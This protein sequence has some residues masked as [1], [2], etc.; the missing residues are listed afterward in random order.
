MSP[1]ERTTH[2]LPLFSRL[3]GALC[4]LLAALCTPAI[5]QQIDGKDFASI[6]L[7]AP[8]QPFDIDIAANRVWAWTARH[9]NRLVLDRDVRVRIGPH[10]FEAKR[11]VAWIEPVVINEHEG[12]QLAFYFEGVRLSSRRSGVTVAP[13]ADA[14]DRSLLV[15]AIVYDSN[16]RLKTDKLTTEQPTDNPFLERAEQ[17]LARYL[18]EIRKQDADRNKQ[19]DKEPTP[20]PGGAEDPPHPPTPR[21][22][23]SPQDSLPARGIV[24][25]STTGTQTITDAEDGSRILMMT[26]GAVVQYAPPDAEPIQL[27]AQRAVVFLTSDIDRPAARVGAADVRGIYLEGDVVAR[28]Q[29]ASV[30]GSRVYYD[31]ATNR[32][33]ALDAVFW[34]YDEKRG[35]PLY[36]RA[37][38]IRQEALNQWSGEDVTLSNVA[39]A[40]PHFSIGAS[41]VTITHTQPANAPD[42]ILIDANRVSFRAGSIPLFGAS[43][44]HGQFK[45]SPLRAIDFRS[46]SGDP[47]IRTEWDAYTLL[48]LD[49]SEGNRATLLLD[50]YTERGPGVGLD[51]EW[52]QNDVVGNLLAYLI[53][54]N[55]TDRLTSGAEKEHDQEFRGMVLAEQSWQLDENWSIL[56]EAAYVSDET[57][58]DAFFEELAETRRPFMSGLTARRHDDQSLLLI[59]ASAS[60]NDFVVSESRLQSYGY[61]VEKLPEIFYARTADQLFGSLFS[62]SSEYRASRL[63]LSLSK[64]KL[65]EQGFDTRKRSRAAVGLDPNDTIAQRLRNRGYTEDDLYRLDTRH[66]L[67]MP[68]KL[69]AVNVVPFAVGRATFWDNDFASFAPRDDSDSL[70][71]WGA[72][73]ARASTSFVHIDR[74]AKNEILDI[75]GLRH[76]VEPNATVWHADTNIEQQDLPIYDDDVE[77]LAAGTT[78]RAGLRNTWQTKRGRSDAKRSVDLLTINSDYL[79]ASGDVEEESPY[80]RF[81]DA[82]PEHSSFGRFFANTAV[83]NLTSAFTLTSDVL[84]N[85]DAGEMA[86]QV[87][88]GILDHGNGFSSFAE[89]RHITAP[90]DELVSVGAAYELNRKY[91]MAAAV[92]HDIER[93]E[94]RRLGVNFERRFPQW[95]VDFVFEAD[96]ITSDVSFGFSL[97]PVGFAGETRTR[98]FTLDQGSYMPVRTPPSRGRIDYGPFADS[99]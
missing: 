70:R 1:S 34:T 99:K 69:G 62:Y 15:T 16:T 33:I 49:P 43:S 41:R 23:P 91:A 39:F 7:P 46:E 72:V 17:R 94:F 52:A 53:Y 75:D 93:G 50:A 45:P 89:Y 97:R 96:D 54:D 80:A 2:H 37:E 74:S 12:D 35:M 32:A 57:F 48:G 63:Q 29:A 66:E 73:G 86:R 14:E 21:D 98:A 88:G 40:E 4:A 6:D 84:F 36:M 95:T 51:L 19:P 22:D 11:A 85:T 83:L 56:A 65:R 31:L 47:I 13:N 78:F 82:R 55:G 27:T 8:A 68:L 20:A 76:I 77:S 38:A 87:Y 92:T 44:I 42:E 10:Q 64:N 60:L 3:A 90:D 28:S 9:T 24:Y 81:I 71:L 25:L 18:T 26:G 5:A 67:E 61:N 59:H 30:R 79:W 58:V